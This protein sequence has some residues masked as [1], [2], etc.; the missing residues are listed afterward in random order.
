MAARRRK[1]TV[2]VIGLG[3]MGGAFAKN[4]VKAGWRV[5]G[6]DTHPARRRETWRA[7]VEIAQNAVELAASVPTILTSLP[8]P[9]ALADTVRKIAA[10][11][12]KRKLLV[13]MSTFKI[14]DKEKAA[15]VLRKA[16]H[17]MIDCP[18]SG[19]GAQAKVKDLVVYASG[20]RA[21][22]ERLFDPGEGA[23]ALP[24]T[25]RVERM[26]Q[27][28]SNSS[29]LAYSSAKRISRISSRSRKCVS[30]TG[31]MKLGDCIWRELSDM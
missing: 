8:K 29:A 22:Y 7:G 12:L 3:I 15:A 4:L 28:R 9:D 2:G 23:R 17:Q 25:T 13:E 11:K 20:D 24:N 6:Y 26:P 19:T 18:V 10:A 31:R 1:G 16:G 5:V 21:A 30:S 27:S 14:S